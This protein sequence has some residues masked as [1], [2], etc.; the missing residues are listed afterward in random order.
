VRPEDFEAIMAR[1]W[2]V[3]RD[4]CIDA[5]SLILAPFSDPAK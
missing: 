5:V 2:Q 4:V 1:A 3:V